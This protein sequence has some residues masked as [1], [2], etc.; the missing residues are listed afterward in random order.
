MRSW[1]GAFAGL[2]IVASTLTTAP[3]ALGQSVDELPSVEAVD[4]ANEPYPLPDP[5]PPLTD[6]QRLP[7]LD[8]SDIEGLWPEDI[9]EI[10]PGKTDPVSPTDAVAGEEPLLDEGGANLDA[11]GFGPDD[12]NHIALVY[13]SDVNELKA[14]G[15]WKDIAITLTPTADG[16][17]WADVETTTTFPAKLSTGSPV[18]FATAKGTL[19]M[20]PADAVSTEA[21]L[22]GLTLTY[23][24]ASGGGDLLYTPL[25]GGVQ[26]QIVLT[27]PPVSPT[28]SF[29]LTT[30]G[31]T[32]APNAFGGIDVLAGTDVV[33]RLPAPVAYDAAPEPV[34]STGTYLLTETAP[35][36]YTLDIQIDRAYLAGAAY[37][38]TIDPTWND[39][40]SRDT[41]TSS[42][43]P[44]TEY[45][46]NTLLQV[47]QGKRIYLDF[48]T[49]NI[50]RAER[51]VYDATLFL[52]PT[53]SGGVT[54]GIDAKRVVDPW[55]TPVGTLNWNNQPNVGAIQDTK[56]TADG[57][58]WWSWNVTNLY[59]RYIDT[60]DIWN[61][62]WSDRG[63][64][65]A[66]SNPKTFH[67]VEH[68]LANSEPALYVTFNDLP[69]R[70]TADTPAGGYVTE[71]ESFTLKIQSG[72]A[73]WPGDNN[74]DEVLVA[75]QISDQN[76]GDPTVDYAGTHKIYQ[77][78][79]DD[80][81]SHSVPAGVLR[82]G[83]T[84][85]WRAVSLDVCNSQTQAVCSLTDGAGTQRQP[86]G[87]TPRQVTVALR[88]FG[89]DDRWAMWSHDVGNG[90]SLEVN[91]ANGNLYLD[92]PLDPTPR[93][94]VTSAS[95]W[96]TTP[97]RPP[98]TACPRAG[99]WRSGRA[100]A[101]PSSP[102]R[103]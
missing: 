94:S 1:G 77:S 79:Y 56:N 69:Q 26:E 67:A 16:W 60:T 40:S 85:W 81:I 61:T 98:T 103:S 6:E 58:G 19:T 102:S 95:P 72:A 18:S 62:H 2:L 37:P 91:Q 88:H 22:S 8:L 65:L 31:L 35:G 63:V 66:A 74:Q 83:Q 48:Q 43:N 25:L 86:N 28:F 100:R 46:S 45:E 73:N 55:P 33:A 51:L 57:N 52:Y 44:S 30:T 54:G 9:V 12:T 20:A 24:G 78:P 82:D 17:T 50:H 27:A 49:A 42:A 97:N 10:V 96:P 34:S 90:A 99:R 14:N 101:A 53:G 7:V 5:P 93:R 75:F 80:K 15:E 87:T 71:S 89:H 21:Q 47:D 23:P 4:P 32:L 3:V 29:A 13:P 76:T 68:S 41:Y 39:V 70:P 38:V 64:A 11:F 36:A 59:Q 92:V 84:Y